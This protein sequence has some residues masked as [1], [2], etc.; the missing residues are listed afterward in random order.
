MFSLTRFAIPSRRLGLGIAVAALAIS[1][2]AT[3]MSAFAAQTPP[4]EMPIPGPKS[5]IQVIVRGKETNGTTTKFHFLLKNN[6]PS[7]LATVN[8]YKE[9]HKLQVAGGSGFALVDNGYLQMSLASGQSKPVTV[10]C[11]APVN[12]K[13]TQ[14]T[15]IAMN[16]PTDPNGGNNIQTITNP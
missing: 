11:T 15:V 9:G 2:V 16:N 8:Y 4:G 7:N 12:W 13:C 14:A 1:A 3:P 5:D 10:T 6:G